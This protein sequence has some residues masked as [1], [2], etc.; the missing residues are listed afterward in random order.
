MIRAH[1]AVLSKPPADG[2]DYRILTC[3]GGPSAYEAFEDLVRETLFGTPPQWTAGGSPG[4][5][6]PWIS[7]GAFGDG[8]VSTR[9]VSVSVTDW[10]GPVESYWDSSGR[11]TAS[12]RYFVLPYEDLARQGIGLT[13]LW[14]AVRPVELPPVEGERPLAL[15][16]ESDPLPVVA[17]FVDEEL[18]FG[19]AAATAAVALETPLSLV[20]RSSRFALTRLATID[21]VAWLLPYGYRAALTASTWAPEPGARTPWL[22]YTHASA[23]SRIRVHEG[24]APEPRSRAAR[25]HLA[26]VRLLRQELGTLGTLRELAA[27]VRPAVLGGRMSREPSENGA[28]TRGD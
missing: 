22:C 6:L 16:V 20:S 15:G 1:W 4:E 27:D 9:H 11:R 28:G 25:A 23:P 18:G 10:S 17:E 7:F 3:S 14:N 24:V 12:T 5:G 21:A 26:R 19:W 2:G 13:G 8:E